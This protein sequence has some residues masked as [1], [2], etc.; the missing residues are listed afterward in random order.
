MGGAAV[1]YGTG[2]PAQTLLDYL[3]AG[4]PIDDFLEE[5]PFL[6]RECVTAFLDEATGASAHSPR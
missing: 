2:V 5:F 6:T 3:K 1:F 4:D